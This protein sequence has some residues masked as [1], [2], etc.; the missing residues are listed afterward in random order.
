VNANQ[1]AVALLP[2]QFGGEVHVEDGQLVGHVWAPHASPAQI[3]TCGAE[4]P[5]LGGSRP[6]II[7]VDFDE[8]EALFKLMPAADCRG[9]MGV[10]GYDRALGR[11]TEAPPRIKS[12][13]PGV[14]L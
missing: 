5:E 12:H 2:H 7:R 11:A 1:L 3:C 8:V 4:N 6:R 10:A 9:A 13:A 14:V